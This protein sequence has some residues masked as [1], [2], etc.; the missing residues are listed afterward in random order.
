[1]EDA[2][3]KIGGSFAFLMPFVYFGAPM[4]MLYFLYLMS[5]IIRDEFQEQYR[6][7]LLALFKVLVAM[8]KTRRE[9]KHKYNIITKKVNGTYYRMRRFIAKLESEIATHQKKRMED[10]NGSQVD[11]EDGTAYS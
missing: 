9:F 2:L 5:L 6:R 8:V 4:V 1:M 11:E 3:I 7:A 10:F